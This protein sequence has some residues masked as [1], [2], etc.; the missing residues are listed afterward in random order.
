MLYWADKYNLSTYQP[1]TDLTNITCPPISI[2]PVK[3][4][5]SYLKLQNFIDIFILR[6]LFFWKKLENPEG[7]KRII[8]WQILSPNT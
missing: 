3:F 5:H 6:F 7:R 8:A 1:I 4:L 2:L